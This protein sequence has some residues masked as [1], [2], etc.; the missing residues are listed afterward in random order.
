M[1]FGVSCKLSFF[2]MAAVI[3][4]L[5]IS[6]TAQSPRGGGGGNITLGSSLVA[7]S[8]N[9]TWKSP[10]GEFAFGFR[11]VYPGGYLLAIWFDEMPERTIIWSANRNNL[12]QQGSTI[13]LSSDGRFELNDPT[14]G[15]R[16]WAASPAT[17]G[18]AYAAMLDS[19]DFVLAA[20]SSAVTWRSFDEPTDTL[21]PSQTLDQGGSIF[22]SFS[23]TNHSIG[24]FKLIMQAD[25][26]LVMYTINF[27]NEDHVYAYFATNTVGTGFRLIFN[28]SGYIYLT[29]RNGTILNTLSS[30]GAP[31]SLLHQRLTLDYDGVLRHY[32]YPKFAN[33]TGGRPMAWS[34]NEFEPS[35]ICLRIASDRGFGAC[36]YNSVCTLGTDQR[37]NCVCPFAYSPIDPNDRMSGCKQDFVPQ[38]CDRNSSREDADVFSFDDMPNTDWQTSDYASFQ[39]V[40]E[41]SCRQD[42]LSDC[43]CAVAIYSDNGCYKKKTP[44]SNGKTDSSIGGKA[45]VKFSRRNDTATDP[46]PSGR[47]S[48]KS[49]NR[50]A[51]IR[52]GSVLLG[53]SVFLNLILLSFV[54]FLV[55]CYRARKSKTAIR[56]YTA[57]P[58]GVVSM[59]SFGF[60]EL[61][62][63]TNGFN[64]EIGSGACSTVYKGTFNEGEN[65]TF[66]AVKKLTKIA[67]EADQE[68]KA[69]VSSISRTNHKNLVRL[70]GY[71]D[72]GQN[73][74]LV[75]EYMPNGSLANF[76]FENPSPPNWYRRVQIAFATARGLCYLHEEC[77]TQIIHCDIK[78]QNVLL[79]GSHVAKIS[80][81]GLA[82][83]LR[84]DQTRT[85][86]GIRGTR[87][88]VAPEWFRNMPIT[89][90]VDV[91][92][93][94][95]LLLELLCC[96]RNFLPDVED[97]KVVLADWAYDC[98]RGGA[99]RSLA[100]DDEVAADDLKRFERFVMVAIW[101]VQEDP[102][103]RPHMKRVMHMLEGSV[104]VPAPPD[105]TSFVS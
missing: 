99:I 5:P 102:A 68:F 95:I 76:L 96:R 55:F 74:L 79:D 66:V 11:Q 6:A 20:N 77:T 75:Y 57:V 47:N 59:R 38:S 24:R 13:Q 8:S 78:P 90:K 87:G 97:E 52:M 2:T 19:G 44:L 81:F 73:R 88:Y 101:C 30:N 54:L 39:S 32:V 53:S 62:E 40:S 22:A 94:G 35:N 43:F 7:D 46:N 4:L 61:K 67:E 84:A 65:V 71:C 21:L 36:G 98:Y 104:Q 34:V 41:D 3:I 83:L 51:L 85:N 15:R 63:A 14:A 89:V 1:G 105:P 49:S 27:P 103:L 60:D 25:G 29:A 37:P 31:T 58:A 91:Y 50:S 17:S 9:S 23:D 16:I 93:Y 48:R 45:L 18:V 56:A 86:T 100:A 80:D 26:N 33:A 69:E 92:S 64:E 72:E 12:A 82:K 10:S 28:Q 42:C 70:L